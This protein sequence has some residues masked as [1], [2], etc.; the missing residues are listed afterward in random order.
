MVRFDCV[1][2]SLGAASERRGVLVLSLL[3]ILIAAAVLRILAFLSIKQTV[4]FDYLLWDE[5]LY[6][7]LAVEMLK[8][9]RGSASLF[10]SIVAVLYRV[11]SANAVIIRAMNLAAGVLTCYL[12]YLLGTAL[13]SRRSGL[14]AC[15]LS[16][17]YGPFIFYSVVPLNTALSVLFFGLAVY[18][19]LFCLDGG[20]WAPSLLLGVSA[21]LA[22]ALRPNFVLLVPVIPLVL[23]MDVRRDRLL[24][25]RRARL[26]LAYLLGLCLSVVSLPAC[27]RLV[28]GSTRDPN[29]LQ[30]VQ[31]GMNFYL[32]NNLDNPVPYFGPARFASTVPRQQ[33][34]DFT[35]EASRRESRRLRPD[36]ASRFWILQ[37]FRDAAIRP[38]LF[39]RKQ[40]LKAAAVFN[41]FEAGDHYDIGFVSRFAPFFRWPWLPFW[42]VM[43]LGTAGMAVESLFSR[44][45]RALAVIFL[46]YVLTL[47]A[48]FTNARYRLVL[49]TILIPF[50]AVGIGRLAGALQARERRTVLVY[51]AVLAAFA[52]VAFLPLPGAGDM[53]PYYNTH[54]VVLASRGRGREAVDYWRRSSRSRYYFADFARL[55]LA[56]H[57]GKLGDYGTARFYLDRI[58][59]SSFAAAYK[60]ALLGDIAV[61]RGRLPEAVTA[62][63]KSLAIHSG[64][65]NVRR[66]LIRV[67]RGID[68]D[69][70]VRQREKL[71]Y[72]RS[73]Y[74]E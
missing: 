22:T 69:E 26:M 49:L 30:A 44:K 62:Y 9:S 63:R 43:P 37:V 53:S 1:K 8:E 35:I 74:P 56:S 12:V 66:N 2:E 51:F 31:A 18:L 14:A 5:R 25:A 68:A 40:I 41:R 52:A 71:K 61:L 17:L 58:D 15:L 45:A 24:L 3:A 50:A 33:P 23:L 32:G 34:I 20:R 7:D 46:C 42:L 38:L 36:E 11:F 19:L 28:Y 73:F 60:L 4:Y 6:H 55:A 64:Q 57:Y 48:F 13:G 47:V 16:S 59:D 29:K 27:N 67:L 54:G 70:A 65:L 21:Y 39:A 72:I 10:A